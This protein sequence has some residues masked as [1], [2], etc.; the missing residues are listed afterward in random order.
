[1]DTIVELSGVSKQYRQRRAL[2]RITIAIGRGE[3]VGL[4]GS[5]GAGKSTLLR[6]ITGLV[7]P[8]CGEVRLFGRPLSTS[9]RRR[10]GALI[11]RADTYPYL[12]GAE[13]LEIV[14]RIRGVNPTRSLIETLLERV[15]LAAAMDQVVRTYS[16]GM[17]QRLGLA[18][19]LAG[20][21]ELVVLDEPVNGLDP[22]GIADVRALIAS[23]RHAGKTVIV[24]S[25]LLSEVELVATRLV[26]LRDGRIIANG[27]LDELL[28]CTVSHA[29]IE[30][31]QP[32]EEVMGLLQSR[33][34]VEKIRAHAVRIAADDVHNAVVHLINAGVHIRAVIP[35]RSLEQ[36][37][38]AATT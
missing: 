30:T 26:V 27:A 13:N 1:M 22:R 35:E 36:F 14:F 25:H 4:L 23:L 2:D 9:A 6:I 33:W 24:S 16:Y 20:D 7:Q 10:I 8:T 28:A 31:Q 3:V 18:I 15:G 5:N 32:A 11:E 21:P 37:Y 12:T 38:F 19:A 17:R 34:K 29:T